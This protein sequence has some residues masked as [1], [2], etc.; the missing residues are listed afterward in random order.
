MVIIDTVVN[1]LFGGLTLPV[2]IV[3]QGTMLLFL[4][5]LYNH[6]PFQLPIVRLPTVKPP[7]QSSDPAS[8]SVGQSDRVPFGLS[9]REILRFSPG[10][11]FIAL[12]SV[13]R[14]P[15]PSACLTLSLIWDVTDELTA[16]I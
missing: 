12:R 4:V 2:C 3:Q 13:A 5:N 8:H 16:D 10:Y 9:R 6:Q 7:S 11:P 15:Q 14:A 1:T